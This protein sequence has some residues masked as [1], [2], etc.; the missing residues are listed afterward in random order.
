[1][2]FPVFLLL[3]I[4]HPLRWRHAHHL[5]EGAAE[6][7]IAAKSALT[8]Q[9]LHRLWFL[10]RVGLAIELGVELHEVLYAQAVDVGIVGDALHGEIHVAKLRHFFSNYNLLHDKIYP[11]SQNK[12]LAT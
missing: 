6:C 9:L 4:T 10:Q 8:G 2:F 1:M 7:A 3:E 12:E 5:F 11:K